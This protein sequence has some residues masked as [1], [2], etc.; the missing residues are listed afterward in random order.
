MGSARAVAQAT[1]NMV[2]TQVTQ[3]TRLFE[4][5]SCDTAEAV[6]EDTTSGAQLAL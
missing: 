5:D 1:G 4:D 3:T 2:L 6:I